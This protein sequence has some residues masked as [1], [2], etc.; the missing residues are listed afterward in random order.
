MTSNTAAAA[1]AAWNHPFADVQQIE[2]S[3]CQCSSRPP[4]APHTR[5]RYGICHMLFFFHSPKLYRRR[6]SRQQLHATA[7]RTKRTALQAYTRVS[8][9]IV[10]RRCLDARRQ[11]RAQRVAQ[12][13][14]AL[15]KHTSGGADEQPSG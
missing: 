3:E 5:W 13:R 14:V 2:C 9:E 4:A 12:Q 1:A 10:N 7:G 6:R 8:A 11:P 15:D